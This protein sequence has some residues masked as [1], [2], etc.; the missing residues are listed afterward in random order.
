MADA[1]KLQVTDTGVI[2]VLGR[3]TAL[4]SPSG[5]R[6][7]YYM[8]G[9]QLEANARARFDTKTDPGGRAWAKWA[10]STAAA[11]R[12]EG[13]GTVLEY[14]RRMR[15]SLTHRIGRSTSEGVEVGFGVP[16]AAIH[17]EGA[18]IKARSQINAH[19][20]KG[21]FMSRSKAAKRKRAVRISFSSIASYK[22][23]ARHML[24]DGKTL[25]AKDRGD[26]IAIVNRILKD[27]ALL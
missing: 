19:D 3:I 26:I 6:P 11:R 13:R 17:E 14:S 21:R 10:D 2:N 4:V 15:E 7:I 27:S 16:Y 24:F 20:K 23:P 1:I 9:R 8:I 18:T 12:R 5:M 22:I 25:G